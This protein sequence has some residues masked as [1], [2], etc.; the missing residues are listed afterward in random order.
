M[1]TTTTTTTVFL[2]ALK[3]Y[4]GVST[5]LLSCVICKGLL[6]ERVTT[7]ACG[8]HMCST[9]THND[10]DHP[11]EHLQI[12]PTNAVI[13][14]ALRNITRKAP[15]GKSFNTLDTFVAHVKACVTCVSAEFTAIIEDLRAHRDDA[16]QKYQTLEKTH[17][18]ALQRKNMYHGEY[19]KSMNTAYTELKRKHAVLEEQLTQ[20]SCGRRCKRRAAAGV[21]EVSPEIDD[22]DTIT[23]ESSDNE[24][25]SDYEDCEEAQR[26]VPLP[27]MFMK[28]V[29]RMTTEDRA[30]VSRFEHGSYMHAADLFDMYRKWCDT[31]GKKATTLH[32]FTRC[33]KNVCDTK[34]ARVLAR[35]DADQ[36]SHRVVDLDSFKE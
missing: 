20:A 32:K 15:C 16:V 31:A 14:E 10:T 19:S 11:C 3:V 36:K 24:D 8:H 12:V 13:T 2:D 7:Y 5:P 4:V 9:C 35:G 33:I 18:H 6:C 30:R 17:K 28:T 27:I 26:T 34:V 25:D 29:A 23:E 21:A 22:Q 1:A